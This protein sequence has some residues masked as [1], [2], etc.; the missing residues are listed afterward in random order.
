MGKRTG[1]IYQLFAATIC[2][3]FVYVWHG[4]MPNVLRWSVLNYVGIVTETAGRSISKNEVYQKLEKSLLS[5]R[6]RR[7]LHAAVGAPVF[8]LSII[9]NM[10]FLIGLDAGNIF[11][12]RGFNSWPWGTPV[13]LFFMYCGAQ[14]SIEVKNWE[15]WKELAKLSDEH[16]N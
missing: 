14:T 7:R 1:V 16:T 8:M 2:F 15:I 11:M 13:T 9:S 12:N 3:S 5:P 6:G 4:I 10:Y